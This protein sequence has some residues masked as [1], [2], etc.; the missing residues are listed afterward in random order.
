MLISTAGQLR[1]RAAQNMLTLIVFPKRRGV[2]I[3]ISCAMQSQLFLARSC[4]CIR[5]NVPGFSILKKDRE[6]ARM[7]SCAHRRQHRVATR[8]RKSGPGRTARDAYRVEEA[9]VE[10]TLPAKGVELRK[11]LVASVHVIH[12]TQFGLPGFRQPRVCV[13]LRLH[14]LFFL[15]HAVLQRGHQPWYFHPLLLLCFAR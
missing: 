1:S 2:L 10:R 13:C 5:A 14:E 15:L 12:G 4:A 7:K 3:R 9:L 8:F 11:K 6:V